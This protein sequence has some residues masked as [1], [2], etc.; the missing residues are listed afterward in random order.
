MYIA[1]NKAIKIPFSLQT[2]YK[3]VNRNALLDSGATENFIHLRAVK[4]LELK[5]RGLKKPR[6]VQNVDR[7]INKGGKIEHAVTLKLKHAGKDI[8]HQFFVADIGPNNFI[9]GYP[10]LEAASPNIDWNAGRISGSVT[11]STEDAEK[12]KIL[13]RGT[14]NQ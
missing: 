9:F 12:W 10:F 5:T 8:C 1:R 14:K 3:R 6:N 2:W 13:P 7:T 4:Q 11:A